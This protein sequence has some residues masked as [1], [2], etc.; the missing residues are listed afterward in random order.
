M[1]APIIRMPHYPKGIDREFTELLEF[2]IETM[3]TRFRNQAL[4]ALN[5]STVEKFADAQAGNYANIFTKLARQATRKILRQFSNEAIENYSFK[6]LNKANKYNRDETYKAMEKA[7]GINLKQ[8]IAKEALSPQIN[9]LITETEVWLKRLRDETL[10]NFTANSLRAMA[11]GND[12]TGVMKQ[13]DLSLSKQKNAAK[14][15][16]RNQLANFN[17]ILTKIRHQ[18][19]GIEKGIWQTSEDEKVRVC[20]Q[21]RNGKKFK[22]SEGCYSSCDDQWLLPGTD[23]NCRC[24]YQAVIKEFEGL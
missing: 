15:I 3:G 22:L 12:M 21:K 16:A 13:F 11:L 10:Q 8:L 17:G 19:V 6:I 1:R 7:L 9:A 18:K 5:K 20:H 4:L 14:F 23:Y 24:V 2:M